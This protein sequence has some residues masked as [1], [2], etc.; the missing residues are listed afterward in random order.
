MNATISGS[1]DPSRK[2]ADICDI[3]PRFRGSDGFLE[4]FGQS[5]TGLASEKKRGSHAL[6]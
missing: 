3:D 4:V 1:C 6:K 2:E 5:A